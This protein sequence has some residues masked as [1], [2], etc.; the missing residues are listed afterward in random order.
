[1]EL[2]QAH[3][4]DQWLT[5]K[6]IAGKEGIPIKF[7]EQILLTLKHAGLIHSRMGVKGGYTLA[8]RPDQITFGAIIR[9]FEGPI[10]PIQCV[11][12]EEKNLCAELWHCKFHGVMV[13]LREAISG[14]VDKTS[15]ADVIGPASPGPSPMPIGVPT[16][17][18]VHLT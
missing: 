10:A 6:D 15:L 13:R 8:K 9:I 4:R 11:N 2:A 5:A 18:S 12:P 16:A 14:V 7:L 1:M 3:Q 17:P